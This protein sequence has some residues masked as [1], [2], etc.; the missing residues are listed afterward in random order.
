MEG[1]SGLLPIILIVGVFWLLL[2]R[3][4]QKR[5]RQHRELIS[6]IQVGDEVVTIGGMY[7]SVQRQDDDTVWLKVSDDGTVLRFSKGSIGQRVSATGEEEA[8]AS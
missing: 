8:P 2:I 5:A 4:Q 7:G 3:P 6:S 1:L